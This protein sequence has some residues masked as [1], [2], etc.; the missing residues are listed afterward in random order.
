MG[1]LDLDGDR[2]RLSLNGVDL[3][4]VRPSAADAYGSPFHLAIEE[5]TTF[6][7]DGQRLVTRLL[8]AEDSMCTRQFV[9]IDLSG[10]KPHVTNR[11]G[12]N[13]DGKSCLDYKR[14]VWGSKQSKIFLKDGMTFLY[15]AGGEV[16]GPI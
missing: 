6:V 15:E 9:I 2:E 10:A 5:V 3:L 12:Y 16:I 11:F 8:V 14:A 13:P 1:R 4:K 7:K